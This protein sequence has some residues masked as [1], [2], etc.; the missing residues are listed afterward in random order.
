L[1]AKAAKATSAPSAQ[2]SAEQSQSTPIAQS[3][4][5]AL[6]GV[7]TVS[8]AAAVVEN[9]TASSV[10]TF[11]PS[12]Q[13]FDQT[14]FSGRFS[15]M[16]LAC[17]PRLLFYSEEQ[18]RSSQQMVINYKDYE[19]MD[20]ALW[21]ARRIVESALHPDTGDVIPRPFRMSGYVPYNGP[22]CV[23]I[24]ASQ[25]TLPLLF[26]AWVNQSQNALV[27]YYNRNGSSPMKNETLAMS[28][29]AAVGSALI[30]A[31]GLATAIQK[32]FE[33]SK[34]K[35]LLKYVAFPSAVVASTL[36]CYI[37]RSPEIESGIPLTDKAGND[38]LP[39]E[40]SNVAAALG[41]YSTT[42][43]RAI[44]QVPVYLFTPLI[45]ALPPFAKILTRAPALSVPLTTYMVLCC[46]GVGLPVTTAI[47]PQI[48]SIPAEDVEQQF[49]HLR[50][51]A[52]SNK[53]Y[54]VYYY[55]K[56]L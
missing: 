10:P 26:W 39:G 32:R 2:K 42:A 6:L 17:D 5:A 23:A 16:L 15:K 29:A 48:S 44:L 55:N 43:S 4:L 34:A 51:P 49:Q 53:T 7:A 33:P 38:V 19:G 45:L 47:F 8:A 56:G 22:I 27:N 25:S 40:T 52:N 36:N 28:Y 54:E 37:I 30:V 1:D 9:S 24:V 35:Q 46:F 13:R 41:V 11:H 3:A 50:D 31:F 21:E 12:T 14:D 20:R 18:V